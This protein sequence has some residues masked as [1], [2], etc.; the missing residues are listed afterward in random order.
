MN[1]NTNLTHC[2]LCENL[3]EENKKLKAALKMALEGYVGL[4]YGCNSSVDEFKAKCKELL[5]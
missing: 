3:K 2:L 1:D 5:K 4:A